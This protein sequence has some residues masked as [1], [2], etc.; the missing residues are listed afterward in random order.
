MQSVSSAD[1]S[2]ICML[3]FFAQS[4]PLSILITLS[5]SLSFLFPNRKNGNVEGS[6]GAALSRKI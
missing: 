1:V 3:Y 5:L 2:S 6:F 4:L